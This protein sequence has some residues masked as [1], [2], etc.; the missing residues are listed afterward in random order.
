MTK[1]FK[2]LLDL[3]RSDN[4]DNA[5]LGLTLAQNF[6]E[7]F[8]K[9]VKCSLEDYEELYPFLQQNAPIKG[10]LTRI[11]EVSFYISQKK[12]TYLPKSIKILKKVKRLDLICQGIKELP[13][14]I[15][16]MSNLQTLILVDNPFERFPK[17]I[18]KL[19]KLH[20]LWLEGIKFDIFPHEI[21]TLK[22]LTFLY[23]D[24]IQLKKFAKEIKILKK[25]N[26]KLKVQVPNYNIP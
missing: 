16:K 7:E 14:E 15:G 18:E 24:D 3:L 13:A 8:E 11:K 17:E 5:H 22:N 10:L 23:V 19:K 2:N 12:I 1:E 25:N 9:Y 4:P 20:S 6:K 26:K 21:A